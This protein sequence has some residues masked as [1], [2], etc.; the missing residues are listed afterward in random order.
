M[1]GVLVEQVLGTRH[2]QLQATPDVR[3]LDFHKGA[4]WKDE[5]LKLKLVLDPEI[6][7]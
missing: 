5:N 1:W 6:K 3:C 2:R 7:C 4:G